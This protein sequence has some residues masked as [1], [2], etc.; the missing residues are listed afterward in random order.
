MR[1]M[2]LVLVIGLTLAGAPIVAC[3]DTECAAPGPCTTDEDC[4][5][6]ACGSGFCEGSENSCS[7]D[8]GCGSNVCERTCQLSA[9]CK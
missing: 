2:Y 7:S 9:E 4:P 1:T 3:G 5:N 8:S 6:T